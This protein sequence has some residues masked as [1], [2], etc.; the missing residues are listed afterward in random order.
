MSGLARLSDDLV[1]SQFRQDRSGPV[2]LGGMN[3]G[4]IGARS[5]KKRSPA[6]VGIGEEA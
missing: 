2:V 5:V 3:C 6:F 1:H 4:L